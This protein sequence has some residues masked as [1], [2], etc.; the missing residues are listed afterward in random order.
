MPDMPATVHDAQ[1][2][3]ARLR[4]VM[5]QQGWQGFLLPVGDEFMSEYPPASAR[6]LEWLTGFSGSA[7]TVAVLAEKAAL[8]TDGRY[9]LQAR[10]EVPE[11]LY[12]HHNSGELAPEAWLAREA[13]ENAAI[14]YDPWLFTPTALARME[15]AG[16]P[17]NLRFVPVTANPVDGLWQERPAAP[18]SPLFPHSLT[19]AGWSAVE[20]IGQVAKAI[21]E[22]GADAALLTLPDGVAWLLN[23]RA[24]DVETV[25][26]PLAFAL[27]TATGEVELFLHESRV[28]EEILASWEGKVTLHPSETLPERATRFARVLLDSQRS[29]VRFRQM[30]EEKG[31]TVIDAPDPTLLPKACKHPAEIEGMH[32]AHRLDGAALVRFARWLE[33][34]LQQGKV[35]E[36]EAMEA[37]EQCRRHSPDYQA[38]SFTTIAGAGANGA[39]VHYRATVERH[40]MLERG[41]LFLLD[42]GGQYP[43]G[44]TD[45]TRTFAIGHPPAECRQRYTEVLKGHLALGSAVFPKGTTGT[46]LDVLARAPLWRQKLDY[47]HGTGHGVGCFLNVHEG[48]QRISKRGGDVALQP[49]MVLSNEPGYYK[50]GEYGIRIENLVVVTELSEP[51]MNGVPFYGFE[52]LTLFPYDRQLIEPTL[53]TAEEKDAINRYHATV[54]EQLSPLLNE[55]EQAWLAAATRPLQG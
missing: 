28:S 19:H 1:G 42:S 10:Q 52:T 18:A 12:E 20:K 44:T 9:T 6:R 33:S 26:T 22:A 51:G 32:H 7:G 14:A 16:K 49:G 45:V 17:R 36:I 41:N 34:A 55:A 46:Q 13:P 30:L 27:L 3:L 21:S 5:Q 39:I 4:E 43:S 2:K 50:N 37:L 47:D 54:R 25:P 23:V 53:L 11:S 8:F 31:S 24:W 48:P 40:G 35:S 15:K 38:P 29:A